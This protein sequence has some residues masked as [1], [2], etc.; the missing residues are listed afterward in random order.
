MKKIFMIVILLFSSSLYAS[1]GSMLKGCLVMGSMG[2][3][4]GV[5]AGS[6]SNNAKVDAAG[7]GIAGGVS[8]LIGMYLSSDIEEKAEQEA[9]RELLLKNIKLRNQI[10]SVKQRLDL[11]KGIAGPDGIPYTEEELAEKKAEDILIFQPQ[12]GN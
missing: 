12:T 4:G 3:G 7:M 8:C 6:L 5:L 2:I 11:L 9:S 1:F 10:H